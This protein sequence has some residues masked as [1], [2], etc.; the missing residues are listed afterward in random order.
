ML[1]F[2]LQMGMFPREA[3]QHSLYHGGGRQVPA[4]RFPK[5]A[6]KVPVTAVNASPKSFLDHIQTKV[7]FWLLRLDF[8]LHVPTCA[9][10]QYL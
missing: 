4:A 7:R 9:L 6:T 8:P 2:H 3:A 1:G 10:L 5:G